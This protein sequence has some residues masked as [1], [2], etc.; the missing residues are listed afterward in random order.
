MRIREHTIQLGGLPFRY[1]E[2]DASTA[3]PVVLLHALGAGA[4][5]WL[6]S[7]MALSDR[8]RVI[9]LDQRGHGGS[10]RPGSYSFELMRDDLARF[11]TNLGMVRP[12]L[13]GHSMGGTV[14]YLYA[15]EFPDSV[16][17][18]VIVDTPPPFPPASPWPEPEHVPED[19]PFDGRVLVPIIR[20]L[21]APDPAWWAELSKIQIQLLLIGG[22]STSTI[23]QDKLAEVIDRVPSGR[24]VTLE[25]A[26]HSVRRRRPAEFIA[27][28]REFLLPRSGAQPEDPRHRGESD[29]SE[30]PAPPH[31][32]QPEATQQP[33][34]ALRVAPGL[35]VLPAYELRPAR[36][37]DLP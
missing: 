7:A 23:P 1:W 36:G 16:R 33:R 35:P 18:L 28:V 32:A 37:H 14:A 4:D 3:Q 17:K 19:V 29:R 34:G 31:E 22:G 6:D 8:W 30:H 27:L 9:A 12:V 5:D 24:L 13:I 20:Q 2:S 15:E 10:A 25:G 26:G 11:I 21:N